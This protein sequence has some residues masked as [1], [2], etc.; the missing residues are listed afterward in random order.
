MHYV[1]RV[2]LV[3]GLWFNFQILIP[4]VNS[5]KEKFKIKNSNKKILLSL[6][7]KTYKEDKTNNCGENITISNFYYF[8]I[9]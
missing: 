9:I 3:N 8:L 1:C 4:S 6:I 2:W 5:Q 7:Y